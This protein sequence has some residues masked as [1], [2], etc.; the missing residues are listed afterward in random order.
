MMATNGGTV[1]RIRV[2]GQEGD[3]I[4]VAGRKTQGVTLFSID[5]DEKVMSVGLIQ[6]K[7]DDDDLDEGGDAPDDGVV[8]E[9]ADGAEDT[10]QPE[11]ASG[12]AVDSGPTVDSGSDNEGEE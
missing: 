6:E 11:E 10:A 1:I 4:R 3:S 2:H 5:K 12:P 7:D 8:A 9:G